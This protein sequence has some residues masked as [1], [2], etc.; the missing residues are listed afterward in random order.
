MFRK[1]RIR[2]HDSKQEHMSVARFLEFKYKKKQPY[3][4]VDNNNDTIETIFRPLLWMDT[5]NDVFP[6]HGVHQVYMSLW[7]FPDRNVW[8]VLVV[9]NRGCSWKCQKNIKYH[10]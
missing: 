7:T 5:A 9:A 2:K 3:K 1:N 10:L 4:G 6:S 8:F